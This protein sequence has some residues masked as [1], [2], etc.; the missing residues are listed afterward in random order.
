MY[1]LQ[2]FCPLPEWL[3]NWSRPCTLIGFVVAT[4]GMLRTQAYISC[5][6]PCTDSVFLPTLGLATQLVLGL[7]PYGF[8]GSCQE[9][10][11]TLSVLQ[12]PG[13]LAHF[14]KKGVRLDRQ[15]FHA[16]SD[17]YVQRPTLYSLDSPRRDAARFFTRTLSRVVLVT[18][19]STLVTKHYSLSIPPACSALL[20]CAQI[21]LYH[22]PCTCLLC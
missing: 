6:Y 4:K 20:D 12:P 10:A 8:R 13:S 14:L 1:S 3:P 7:Y 16:P 18:S 9:C 5:R 21:L 15:V 11:Q 17:R 22:L 19:L 2:G